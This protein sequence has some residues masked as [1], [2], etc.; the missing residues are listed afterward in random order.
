MKLCIKALKTNPFFVCHVS[1]QEQIY[2]HIHLEFQFKKKVE[3]AYNTV[4]IDI[5]TLERGIT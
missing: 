3:R 5:Y 1:L 2:I 4:N